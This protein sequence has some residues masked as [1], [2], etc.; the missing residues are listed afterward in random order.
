MSEERL[1]LDTSYFQA[2][3]SHRDQFHARASALW[4]RVRK[5]ALAVST[6]A[7]LIE[8]GNGLSQG[9]RTVTAAFIDQLLDDSDDPSLNVE[10]VPIDTNLL[11]RGLE[12]YSSRGDK[13]WGLTD[14]ISFVVMG[15]MGLSHALTADRHFVQAGF[16][17]MLWEKG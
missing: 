10:I 3:L 2:L 12:L 16:R 8:L 15:E 13:D 1:F 6:E 7:V 4:P 17:A 11:R 9:N 5:A 14:C